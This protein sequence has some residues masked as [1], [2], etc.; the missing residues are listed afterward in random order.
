MADTWARG[1]VAGTREVAL[2]VVRALVYF[3]DRT[4]RIH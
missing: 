3:K 4:K 2:E 1:D